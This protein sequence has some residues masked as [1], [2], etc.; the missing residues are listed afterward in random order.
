MILRKLSPRRYDELKNLVKDLPTWE[1]LYQD[2]DGFVTSNP[3]VMSDQ[4]FSDK[5][6]EIAEKRLKYQHYIK[7]IKQAVL[8]T[9]GGYGKIIAYSVI[10]D[11]TFDEMV[12]HGKIA[13]ANRKIFQ[14][15][16]IVFF[17]ILDELYSQ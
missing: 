14:K 12:S 7:V 9:P 16:Y 2:L 4:K 17:N 6:A 11:M 3:E 5:T 13:S 8:R 10:N 15:A 1:K